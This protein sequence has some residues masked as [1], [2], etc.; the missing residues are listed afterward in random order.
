MQESNAHRVCLLL[1]L[2]YEEMWSPLKIERS[3]KETWAIANCRKYKS[4]CW[5][6]SWVGVVLV[7]H[8]NRGM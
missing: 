6:L 5:I 1:M 2:N 8:T 4:K 3:Y 7:I